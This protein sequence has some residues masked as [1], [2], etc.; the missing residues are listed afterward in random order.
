MADYLSQLFDLRGRVAV[1]TGASSGIGRQIAIAVAQ[2][3]ASVVLIGRRENLLTKVAKDINDIT[4]D[5]RALALAADISQINLMESL[6]I[7]IN[8]CFGAVNIVY[9]VAGVN[10]RSSSDM[11]CSIDDI[12]VESWNETM[13][14]NLA[15]PFFL[16]RELVK[17]MDNGGA[18]INI[19]SM[20]SLR[21]GLGDAAYGASK[22][23]VAQLTR[24]MARA[25]GN[26]RITVNAILPGFFPSGITKIVFDDKVL[27]DELAESTILGRNGKLADVEGAAVFLASPAAAYITGML[28]PID[29]GF[30]AK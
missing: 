8:S 29:G 26:K 18:I 17:S 11:A 6:A 19:G 30:L 1:V 27:S 3:G 21:A 10:F 23:G 20:Q 25:W 12:T 7:K 22:G 9:N 2:A 15:A 28:L 13:K 16:T 24:S 14:V 5:K 4:G